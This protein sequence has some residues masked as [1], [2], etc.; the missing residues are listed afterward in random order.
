MNGSTLIMLLTDIGGSTPVN[1]VLRAERAFARNPTIVITLTVKGDLAGSQV[2]KFSPKLGSPLNLQFGEDIRPYLL[3]DP[4]GRPTRIKPDKALTERSRMTFNFADDPNAPDFDSTVFSIFSGSTF[5]R[6]MVLTQPDL[7]GMSIEAKRGY[8]APNLNNLD[9]FLTIFKGRVE[10]FNFERNGNFTLIAK[11]DL[12]LVDRQIPRQISDANQLDGAITASTDAITVNKGTEFFL[13]SALP[14]K[15]LFPVV[16]RLDPDGAGNG[17][18]DVI[19]NSISGNVLTVQ[20]NFLNKSE[21]FD[22]AAWSKTGATVVADQGRGPFGGDQRADTVTLPSLGNLIE[23]DSTELASGVTFVFSVWIRRAG[24]QA[25]DV[26]MKID[27]ILDD[28]TELKEF[29]LTA[30][31]DWQRFEVSTSFTGG[32]GQTAVARVQSDDLSSVVI[33]LYGAQLEKAATRGFYVATDGNQGVDAGRGAFG[34]TAATHI[35][36]TK[37]AEVLPYRLHLDPESGVHPVFILRDLVNRGELPVAS[38][39]QTTFDRE[40]NFIE[41]TQAKRAGATIIAKPRNLLKHVKEVREQFMLDLWAS[42][43]GFVRTRLSFRQNIPGTLAKQI[44]DEANILHRTSSYKGNKESRMT[45]IFA[46]YNVVAGETNPKEPEDFLNVEIIADLGVSGLSGVKAKT[47]LSKWIF[48]SAE[49]VA[50][51]GRLVSR[52][53]RG[54]RIAAWEFDIKDTSEFDVGDV[55]EL[56]SDDVPVKSGSAAVKGRTNWQI[57]Q[58]NHMRSQGKFSIEGLEFSGLRYAIISPN[59]DLETPADPFPDYPAASAAERQYGFI[60]DANNLVNAGSED[61]YYIL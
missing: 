10:D 50:L 29:E 59:D 48:R 27:L 47:I 19:L 46:Y 15:D 45:E 7:V 38:V 49:A 9:D 51:V 43:D 4:R 5:W 58:K 12:A 42:E 52:F 2:F 18:E 20:E 37:L 39:D 13:P 61:G 22:N 8:V 60:G 57:V 1:P 32:A 34:T 28:S 35:D 40:F 33:D 16:L 26:S 55:A 44:T 53:R 21:A 56:N 3:G 30:T 17:P 11:D 36:N 6:R 25:S 31:K 54:A 24:V 23:Q 41:S 14:S